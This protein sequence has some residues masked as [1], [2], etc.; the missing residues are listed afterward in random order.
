MSGDFLADTKVVIWTISRSDRL[1][2]RAKHT[3]A[4]ATKSIIVS[5][6]SV[7]EIIVKHQ[8]GKLV[9]H[10][11]LELAMDQILYR[12]PWTIVP[13]TSGHLAVLATLPM[14]HKDPFDRILIAQAR[15]QNLTIITP[16]EKIR[17]YDV[18]TLW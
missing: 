6:A 1:S 5:V 16:D 9:F 7:W 2:F 15:D 13:I 14:L 12:S 8:A 17:K 4:D 18:E 3:L 11:S 10:M